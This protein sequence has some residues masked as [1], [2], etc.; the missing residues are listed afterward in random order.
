MNDQ[1]LLKGIRAMG[2]HGVYAMEKMQPQPFELDITL[3]L[4]TSVAAKSDDLDAT[5]DYS[6]AAALASSVITDER[7]ELI[8]RVAQRVAE[9][10]FTFSAVS[11]A[12]VEVRK[13]RPTMAVDI[14]YSA[15][16][17]TRVRDKI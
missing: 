8:E 5:V 6:E 1:I 10:M 7:Y 2:C 12:T 9:Q 15:V 11:S 4:D 3:F 17:I 13:L 14:D 16:R